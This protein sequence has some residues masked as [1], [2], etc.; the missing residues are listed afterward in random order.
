M[1]VVKTIR[2]ELWALTKR[3][4]ECLLDLESEWRRALELKRTYRELRESTRLPSYYCRALAWKVR[5]RQSPILLDRDSFEL[6]PTSNRLARYFISIPTPRGRVWCP[7]RLWREH[8]RLLESGVRIRDSK[9]VVRKGRFFLHLTVEKKI[10]LIPRPNV[11]AVDLGERFLAASVA[12]RGGAVVSAVLL[13]KEARGVRRHHAWLRRRLGE[14]KLLRVIRRIGQRERRAVDQICH[15]VAKRVVEFAVRHEAVIVIGDLKG[16]RERCRGK[17]KR[18]NRIVGSMPYHRLR[19][20]IEHKAAWFGIPVYIVSEAHTSSRCHRCGAE[21]S[22]PSQGLFRCRACGLEYNADLNGA[23][24]L[25]KR[26]LEQ[27]S[28]NGAVWVPALK[29]A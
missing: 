23:A 11:V 9:L 20:Y 13:G 2:A 28:G 8:E 14:R 17:G 19:R 22:R 21:G 4:L 6:K 10:T 25:G 1:R 7:L 15:R 24:N 3:K 5:G 16:L 29:A 26:F 27:R 18:L 12:L